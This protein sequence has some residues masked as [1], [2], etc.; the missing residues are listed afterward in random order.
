MSTE[1]EIEVLAYVGTA[2]GFLT[3]VHD[4][5]PGEGMG[6]RVAI[7]NPSND[8]G[9]VS[10]LRLVNPGE[11]AAEV[12]IVGL[13]DNGA[14]PG[15][16]VKTTIPAGASRMLTASVLEAGGAGLTGSLGDGA[17]MWRLIVESAQPIVAMNLLSAPTGHLTNLS[18][19]PPSE[20]D[21]AH[22]V[23]LLPTA[24][25]ALGRE[26]FVRVINLSD[27]SGQVTIQAF[28]GT[29]TEFEVL[30]L[31][32]AGNEAAQFNSDDLENGN[33]DKGLSGGTGLGQGDWRLELTSGLDIR[34]LSYVRA[35]DGVVEAMHDVAS[36]RD[37][38]YRVATF[39]PGNNADQQSLLWLANPGDEAAEVTVTGIDD[40][41]EAPGTA[42]RVT[43]PSG[44]SKR[45]TA[46]ELEAGGDGL[47]GAL[48]DGEGR[49]RLTVESVHPIVVMSLLSDPTGHLANLST[50][51]GP[52][53]GLESQANPDLVTESPA[54][55]DGSPAAGAQFTLSA[56]VRNGGAA[57]SPAAT[58]RYYRSANR[59][60]SSSD[61]QVGT[62]EVAALAASGSSAESFEL[63]APSTAGTYY[64]GAC[65]DAVED[66]SAATNNCS[67]SV[68]VEVSLQADETETEGHPDLVVE[69]VAV[70]DGGPTAG[71]QFALSATVRND[72]DGPA[73]ATTLRYYRSANKTISAFD[74]AAG[75]VEVVRL[76][77]SGSAANSVDVTAPLTA[78]TY[79]YGACVD[80]V[81]SE[82]DTTDNCSAPVQVDVQATS[83]EG[84]PDLTVTPVSVAT[85]P[86][87]IPPGGSFTL[88]ATVR[89]DGDGASGATTL[90]YFRSVNSMVTTSD[91]ALGRDD[92]AQLAASE[93][94]SDSIDLTASSTSGTYYYGA[95][96]DPMADESDTMNNCSA[97]V[98]VD[99]QEP[100]PEPET[101][102]SPNLAVG[103]PT[104]SDSSPETGATFTLSATVSNTG[105]D[106]S[107]ATT[108]RY[109]R[110]ADSTISSSDTEVGTV[111]VGEVAASGSSSQSVELTA[112]ASAGTYYYG[113][114]VDFV[115]DE[116]DTTD[117]CSSSVK[118]DVIK[119]QQQSQGTPDLEMGAPAVSDKSPETGGSFTLSATV[120]NAGDGE[121]VATTLRYYR[122]TDA[123]ISSSD[124]EVGT[125]A[126]GALAESASNAQSLTL[127]APSSAGTYYFGACVDSVAEESDTAD[128]CSASVKVDVQEPPSDL[129]V[130]TPT[131]SESSPE[132]GGSFTLSAT[133]SNTGEGESAATTLRY[134]RSTD[135]SISTS[136]TEVGTDAVA[137]LAAAGTSDQSVDL[138]APS[139][140][141]AYYYGA[142]VDAVARESD[143]TDNCSASVKVDVQEPPSDLEVGTPT[144][145]ESSL[146][147]GGS[148]TLSATVSNTGEGESAATTLRYYRSTDASISTSDTE[149][150]T[151]AVA[152]LA[153]AGTSD[154]S[155]DLT[156][157]STAGAYYY[158]ACVDAVARESDITDN[159]SAS[160]KVDVQE[161]PSDLEVG[162]PTVSES[163]PETGG[164]FTLSATVSNTGEGESAATTLRYY[165]STDAS[166][167]TADT[168]VGTDAVAK[169]AAAGTSDQSVDLTAPSTAG[170]YYYGACVDAVA[171]ES[172]TTDNCSASV[173]VDVVTPP[174]TA[175]SVEVTAPQEWAPVGDSVTYTAKV[176]DDE[177][178][179]ITGTSVSWSSSD[180]AIATVDANG[181]VTAIAEGEATITATVTTS[182][183]A[184]AM[185][186]PFRRAAMDLPFRGAE[187]S[188]NSL[189]GSAEMDVVKRASRV[190]LA[191]TSLSFDEVSDLATLT[192]TIYDADDNEMQPTYYV[193][194]SSNREVATVA[195]AV[196]SSVSGWV[197]SIGE[198][199]T[200]ISLY[201]NGSATGTATVT[202]TLPPARVDISPG[203]L[204]FEALGGTKSVTVRVL[205]E[206][207]D[208]DDDAT[209]DAISAF[210]P[211]CTPDLADPPQTIG[212]KK[213][214][215][216]LE[217][218]ANGPGRGQVYI[219]SEGVERA[220]LLVTVYQKATSLT[221]SPSSPSLA[222]GG[223]KT[224]SAGIADA[225]GNSIHVDQGDGQGG[226]V[227]YWE[228]SDSTVATVEGATAKMDHNT[229]GSA[230]VTAI[231][232]GTATITGRHAGGGGITGTATITVTTVE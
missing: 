65:V 230:T 229:G 228:T 222:V 183:A 176:L 226:L 157:P 50:A 103:L 205:D 68:Q 162:T 27:T 208:V 122:S 52:G 55:S 203:S 126:I 171:R 101:Q 167:S 78:G 159:C 94:T 58:L 138:T 134:Y 69:S 115:A 118:V 161:P 199:T 184:K 141:G 33:S 74:T 46:Q 217:I 142:C 155:V 193:W 129:E 180:T 7:F 210:S 214:D 213:V 218:T 48:G 26:G 137:K 201:V 112:P 185:S 105:D 200:T 186:L 152:K 100:D 153:A 21:N 106:E 175:S 108:L 16:E 13:D 165:R 111:A 197:K 99:V 81:A 151:D 109:Y 10:S 17:G 53:A 125:V 187:G 211:C 15:N 28:D 221:V 119:A 62:D 56:T 212:I 86:S 30:T 36:A 35:A 174:P 182:T 120:S 198:G 132:T 114:C 32:L 202:V 75:T 59:T 87:T 39:N 34:V 61:T 207:G 166:I 51:P 22:L 173:K 231:K 11:E 37:G 133:V 14:S 49:W 215:D 44:E 181:E 206:N 154:Q 23:P 124:T 64:Y 131:V 149:V 150:G 140:A 158:G 163:S 92:L 95:C 43:V 189:S 121:S 31:S 98:R 178:N 196:G 90:R 60:I 57:A 172:D 110:S 179:E 40:T 225:N 12:S 38:Q 136:D 97:A 223:T 113:A 139:T 84:K 135:A 192:A 82:S 195:P 191:P 227:V 4:A 144:V 25:D 224:L 1:L 3:A 168:E 96:V 220:I 6:R 107:A 128:N 232:A 80:A 29:S 83:A 8:D 145:S 148:F 47:E 88:L 42:V 146:E 143:I 85:N 89:N 76:A 160:V 2:D 67:R 194:G 18:T 170:A 5:V 102:S 41:G 147:T 130:G 127:A 24:S 188:S 190:V 9:Q 164:S 71:R 72:G 104:V 20:T 45:L 204:T 73:V 116:S 63:T 70:S 91:A 79:Y 19:S 117:N 209:F 93:S 156:A 177:G 169:L 216:G 66:E 123:T 54:V 219:S 77:A